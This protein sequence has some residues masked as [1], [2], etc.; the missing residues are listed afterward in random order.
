VGWDLEAKRGDVVLHIEV[1]RCSGSAVAAELTP[2]EYRQSR[3]KAKK[4]TY[5]ICVV[6]EALKKPKLYAFRWNDDIAGWTDQNRRRLMLRERI[7]A[8]VWLS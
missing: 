3:L 6:T 1:K 5:R 4:G 8:T 7:G 2:N